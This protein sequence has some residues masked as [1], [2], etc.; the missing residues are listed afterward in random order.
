MKVAKAFAGGAAAAS[1]AEA[2]GE[3]TTVDLGVLQG[4]GTAASQAMKRAI[5]D[6]GMTIGSEC[7]CAYEAQYE[8]NTVSVS[9]LS[10]GGCLR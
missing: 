4:T 7:E 1:A 9:G 8:K 2:A 10:L 3:L 5:K 6:K